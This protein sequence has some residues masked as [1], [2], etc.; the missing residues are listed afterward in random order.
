MRGGRGR[1]ATFEGWAINRCCGQRTEW[2]SVDHVLQSTLAVGQLHTW[3]RECSPSPLTTAS[4]REESRGPAWSWIS[5][6][7]AELSQAAML[8]TATPTVSACRSTFSVPFL[9]LSAAPARLPFLQ[10]SSL[11]SFL[12]RL[13]GQRA[14]SMLHPLSVAYCVLLNLSQTRSNT[15]TELS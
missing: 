6:C 2:N 8:S 5:A 11:R 15:Q 1:Q 7:R 4:L 14:S 12:R 3:A 13:A 9:E 10:D